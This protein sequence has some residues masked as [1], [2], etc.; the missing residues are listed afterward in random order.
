MIKRKEHTPFY[1]NEAF[2]QALK[3]CD[4]ARSAE[5]QKLFLNMEV[6]EMEKTTTVKLK[7]LNGRDICEFE[8][9]CRIGRQGQPCEQDI[10]NRIVEMGYNPLLYTFKAEIS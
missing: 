2:G 6:N 1:F 9:P 10:I 3:E 8:V 7:K 4:E 5:R